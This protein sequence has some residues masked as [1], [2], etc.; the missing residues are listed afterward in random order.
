MAQR[1]SKRAEL[2]ERTVDELRDMARDRGI[3]GSSRMRKSDLVD[4]IARK[5][6]PAKKTTAAGKTIAAG[7]ATAERTTAN[8]ST[9]KKSTANKST[10]NKNTASKSTA[11]KSTANK[12]TAG[13]STAKKST[14]KAAGRPGASRSVRYAQEITSTGDRPERPG[15][16]LVTRDHD[17]IRRWAEERDATPAT[18]EGTEHEGRP[19]VLRFDFPGG[20]SSER[21]VPIDWDDWFASFDARGLNFIY[22]EQR[23]DGRQSNFFQ[24]ENPDREDA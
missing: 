5:R 16:S 9:A 19:G 6:T 14:A 18:I 23:S 24:L 22:Q 7:K 8:R 13:K 15:R 21:L 10:A 11:K 3:A 17:V 4:A 2:A 12:S 1:T 20:E